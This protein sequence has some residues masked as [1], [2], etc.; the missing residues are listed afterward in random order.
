MYPHHGGCACGA[1][2][3]SVSATARRRWWRAGRSERKSGFPIPDGPEA[4]PGPPAER[5]GRRPAHRGRLDR[6]DLPKASHVTRLP[7]EVRGEEC[8]RAFD[9]RLDADHPRPERKH[10]H[11]VVLDALV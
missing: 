9:G 11:V 7:G 6:E 10:V 4:L 3:A 1:V 5:G 2:V 8:Q